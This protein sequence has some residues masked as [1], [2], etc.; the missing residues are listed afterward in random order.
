[1]AYAPIAR[2]PQRFRPAPLGLS[3]VSGSVIEIIG[4]D[5]SVQLPS[6]LIGQGRIA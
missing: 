1:M 2:L 5:R 4:L 3:L 6:D